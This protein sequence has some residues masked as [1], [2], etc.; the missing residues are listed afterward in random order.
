MSKQPIIVDLTKEDDDIQWEEDDKDLLIAVQVHECIYQDIIRPVI[1]AEVLEKVKAG[2]SAT[3]YNPTRDIRNFMAV[4]PGR[5]K[6]RY[7]PKIVK[8][9]RNYK[10]TM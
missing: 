8:T 9:G 3:A 6:L 7:P 1:Q 5:P 4:K 10:N 2:S